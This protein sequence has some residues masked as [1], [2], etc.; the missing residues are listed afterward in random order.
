M[1][2]NK[3]ELFSPVLE[4]FLNI[5]I[6]EDGIVQMYRNQELILESCNYS[7]DVDILGGIT[8]LP[9]VYE[10][11]NEFSIA[12][13]LATKEALMIKAKEFILYEQMHGE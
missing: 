5:V 6:K 8:S 10:Q 2:D 11:L 1:S 13:P 7:D 12:N 4:G 9:N 3:Q